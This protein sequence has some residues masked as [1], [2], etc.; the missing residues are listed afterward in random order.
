MYA[1]I[2]TGGTKTVCAIGEGGR[3][4]ERFQ[5]PTGDDPGALIDSCVQY[6]RQFDIAGLGIGTFG[7]CDPNPQSPKYGRILATPKPG[8][9][10]ADLL[11]GLRD[12][13]GVPAVITTDVNAAALGESRYG[14]AVGMSD[15][16]YLTIGTGIGGG[17][18]SDGR[19]LHGALHPEMGHMVLPQS[20]PDG[21]CAFHGGCFEGLA[22]GPA[23]QQRYGRP[24]TEITDDDPAWDQEAEIVAAGLHNIAC[25]LSPQMFVIGGGVGSREVLHAKLGP[26]LR[27]YIADYLP[28]PEIAAP[29]LG[30]N[31][32]VVG[33]ITLAEEL[34]G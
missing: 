12:G 34:L 1:G 11:G 32:G 29:G 23:M 20:G 16:V 10:G 30:S 14:A 8:W 22:A 27:E 6:L 13:L 4:S 33:A 5:V 9:S 28:V 15:V 24:A 2:E 3:I 25:V 7:P 17:A 31:A 21:A 18:L 19:L 26:A